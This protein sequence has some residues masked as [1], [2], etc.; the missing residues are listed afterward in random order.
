MPNG[1]GWMDLS[2]VLHSYA[3]DGDKQP[4]YMHAIFVVRVSLFV[5]SMFV[6]LR[7]PVVAW[8][9]RLLC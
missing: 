4:L 6:L 8:L 5:L 2:F 9:V 7:E 3:L 1:V